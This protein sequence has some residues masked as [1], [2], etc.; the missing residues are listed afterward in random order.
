MLE[1]ETITRLSPEIN[2]RP[3][4]WFLS[5]G[6]DDTERVRELLLSTGATIKTFETPEDGLP[7][8]VQP[9]NH[10]DDNDYVVWRGEEVPGG[11][12]PDIIVG[13]GLLALHTTSGGMQAY[14]QYDGRGLAQLWHIP[15]V[16]L[17]PH[18]TSYGYLLEI[19]G[20]KPIPTFCSDQ[21]ALRRMNKA[22][23]GAIT[24]RLNAS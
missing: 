20:N 9:T 6:N 5:P 24:S 2:P 14:R 21:T 15:Y 1:L 12:R 19:L 13:T 7:L 4:A 18:H 23:M 10:R 16:D 3:E 22:V 17:A 8:P 11:R